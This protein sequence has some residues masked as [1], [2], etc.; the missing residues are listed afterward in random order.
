MVKELKVKWIE[1]KKKSPFVNEHFG[2]FINDLL[3]DILEKDEFLKY[4]APFLSEDGCSRDIQ[5]I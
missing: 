1:E 5:F 3:H 2:G 4:Y